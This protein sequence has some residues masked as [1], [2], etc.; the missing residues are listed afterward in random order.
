MRISISGIETIVYAE[1]LYLQINDISGKDLTRIWP[2]IKADYINY[3]KWF[4]FR[5]THIPQDVLDSIGATIEDDCTELRLYST[6]AT[7]P[8][9]IMAEMITEETFHE[10]SIFHDKCAPDVYWTGERIGRDL[11]RWG[12]FC[13]RKNGNIIGY[14]TISMWHPTM[15]EIFCIQSKDVDICKELIAAASKYAFDNGKFDV[16]HQ[17]DNN[18]VH[19]AAQALGFVVKGFYKGYLVQ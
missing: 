19:Q 1:D 2:Q 15:A 6:T 17:A 10:F 13:I 5:N 4:C 7:L 16:L 9:N 11:S 8:K 12:I 14:V 3:S 18:T